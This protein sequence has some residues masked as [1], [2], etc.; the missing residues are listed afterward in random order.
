MKQGL[1]YLA[2]RA[3]VG[4]F[5]TLLV[6]VPLLSA[7]AE[8]V[9]EKA[10]F[11][12]TPEDLLSEAKSAGAGGTWKY[13]VSEYNEIVERRVGGADVGA[14]VQSAAANSHERAEIVERLQ[15]GLRK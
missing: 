8:R 15:R 2:P 7:A 5:I 4:R 3:S 9:A 12:A 11:S 14:F 1:K 6:F 13:L 10:A